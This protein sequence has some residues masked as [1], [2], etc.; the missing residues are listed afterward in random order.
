MD[1][2]DLRYPVLGCLISRANREEALEK[3]KERR[4]SGCG[5][6]VC[7]SNVHTVVTSEKND[8][9]RNSTNKSFLSLP[10][11]RPLSLYAHMIGID[12]VEQ[13]AG[14]DFLGYCLSNSPGAR[15]YFYGSTEYTLRELRGKLDLNYPEAVIAGMYSPPFRDLSD[16]ELNEIIYMLQETKP[17][18]IWVGL[19]APKQELWMAENWEALKPSILMGVGAAFDFYAGTL[20][21]SPKWMQKAGLEWCYRLYCE[22]KRLWRRYLVTNS[23]FMWHVFKELVKKRG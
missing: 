19:G 5:G 8:E 6:Y 17:D 2:P 21:R 11:G 9:L 12:D 20:K 14:P 4:A 15:H 3:V 7:F 10:D 13:V 22:P 18:F 1:V 16:K 23:I